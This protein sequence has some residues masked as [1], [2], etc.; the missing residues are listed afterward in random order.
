[1]DKR[2]LVISEKKTGREENEEDIN[3]F[4]KDSQMSALDS[5]EKKKESF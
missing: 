4:G 1:M 5:S 3:L 2:T